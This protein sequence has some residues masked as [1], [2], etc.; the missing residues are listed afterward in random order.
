LLHQIYCNAA[1]RFPGKSYGDPTGGISTPIDRFT[2]AYVGS[3]I[4]LGLFVPYARQKILDPRFWGRAL[5]M[6]LAR[7]V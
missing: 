5:V 4:V 6:N 3:L 2:P 1:Y 7:R